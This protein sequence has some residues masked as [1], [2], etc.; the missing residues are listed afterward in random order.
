MD[1]GK[2]QHTTSWYKSI[3]PLGKVPFYTEGDFSLAESAAILWYLAEANSAV[4]EDHWYPK[5]IKQRS[6]TVSVCH[7][8]HSTVSM[9]LASFVHL[10]LHL[11]Y[12]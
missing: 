3:N 4:I 5:D 1:L 6:K 10:Y 11:V 2:G 7:W 12:S 8:Q 9:T